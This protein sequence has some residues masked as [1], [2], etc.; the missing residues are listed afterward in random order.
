MS[1][2]VDSKTTFK[3][4]EA[5]LLV[6]RVKPDLVTLLA[7]TATLNTRAFASYNTT[8]VELK[9]FIISAGSKSLSI[10]NAMFGPVPKR[11][12]ITMVKHVD[13]IGTMVTN[14]YKF[15]HYM[16][17]FSMFVN[18]KP[19]PNQGLFLGMD[20]EK[21]SVMVYR[22]LFEESGIHHCNT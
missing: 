4:L 3:F 22:T 10:D 12:D 19:L 21:T 9:T 16:S 18:E 14:P 1:K 15:Q 8:R 13:F 5:Q 11:L 17:D 2:D 6:K 7:H 20:H